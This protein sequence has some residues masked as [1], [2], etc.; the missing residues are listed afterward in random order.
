MF[1]L[2]QPVEMI[3]V[4]SEDGS[5]QPVRFR[6]TDSGGERFTVRIRHIQ[7][8]REIRYV[9]VEGFLYVCAVL[10]GERERLIELR[11]TMR[12]HRWVLCRFLDAE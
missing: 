7:T 1:A 12:T 3:S 11:Y 9:G 4:C 2:N 5:M 8:R 6:I 10:L